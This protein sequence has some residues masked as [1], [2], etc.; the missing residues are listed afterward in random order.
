MVGVDVAGFV[1]DDHGRAAGE[2]RHVGRGQCDRGRAVGQ[3]RRSARSGEPKEMLAWAVALGSAAPA[4]A[5]GAARRGAPT[6]GEHAQ[7]R[8]AHDRASPRARGSGA[9][10]RSLLRIGTT[11][12]NRSGSQTLT[13]ALVR[14]CRTSA[15]PFG[16][17][18][19]F[20]VSMSS[21]SARSTDG[22]LERCISE[23]AGPELRIAAAG[24]QPGTLE[25]LEVPGDDCR[26]ISNG[27]A[28]TF[29]VARPWARRARMARRVGSASA[30]KVRSSSSS[31]TTF[32]LSVDQPTRL[33]MWRTAAERGMMHADAARP[34]HEGSVTWRCPPP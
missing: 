11:L 30:A 14:S 13:A 17:S 10:P 8:C 3:S 18:G 4:T 15:P 16:W 25:H 34:S 19:R 20:P 32:N 24:D 12:P 28:S 1:A 33:I 6:Q 29:T 21:R 26:L 7:C 9:R 22:P 23:G 5:G 2:V 31:P 27:S